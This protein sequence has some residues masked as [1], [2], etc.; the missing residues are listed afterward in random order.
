MRILLAYATYSSGTL[1]ASTLVADQLQAQQH[2][3]T[4]R[5]IKELEPEVCDSYETIIFASPSW[6]VDKKESQPH[7]SYKVFFE[8][9][10]NLNLQ[11][12]KVAIFGLGDRAF[13]HFCG[14]VDHLE[15]FV[16][17]HNGTPVIESLRI[18][19]FFFDQQ[20]NTQLLQA[21]VQNLSQKLA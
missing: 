17:D 15:A 21:W 9:A 4:V 7:E 8:R 11:P 2:E 3:V 6:L 13:M 14:A 12:K 5:E 1:T 18:D 19:G 16:K 20:R 10:A